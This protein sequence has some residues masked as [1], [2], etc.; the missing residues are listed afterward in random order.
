MKA[1]ACLLS[2]AV[3]VLFSII[4]GTISF[5]REKP[6]EEKGKGLA[7]VDDF[8]PGRYAILNI[9]NLWAWER[10]DGLSNHSPQG[11]CG[12]FFPRNTSHIIYQD[13]I[14][15]GSKAYLD[16]GKTQ[17]APLGQTIRVGGATYGTG[18]REGWV[19]GYGANAI[20]VNRDH[21]F[22]RLFRIRRGYSEMSE[23][24]LIQDAADCIE[25][26][27][28]EVTADMI[29]VVRDDYAWSW[30]NW[31]VHH[32]APFIDRNG[33][34]VYDPPPPFNI[35]AD[36]NDPAYFGPADLI[37]GGYDEPGIAGADL[38]SPADQVIFGIWNDLDREASLSRFGS[39]P[40]GLEI[41]STLW[42]YNRADALG[43]IFFRKIKF[44][45]KGGVEIDD[46]G[47]MG[48]FY[49][50]S[51]YVCQWSDPDL[52]SWGDD[53]VGCDTTLSMGFVY[54]ANT[55]DIRYRDFGLPPPAGG[56]D[57]LQGP[58]V[59]SPGDVAVFDLEYKQGYRNLGMSGFSYFSAGSPY[60]DPGGGYDTNT[61]QWYKML[62]GYAPLS[63]PDVHY[64][65]PPGVEPGP[66]PLSGDP[67]AGTGHI[68]GQGADYSFAPGDRRILC[69]SGPWTMAPGDTQEVVVALVVGLGSDR[70]SS[71]N[72][73]KFND[74]F[75][76]ATYNALFAIPSAPRTPVVNVAELDGRI[77]LEWGSVAGIADTE[78]R[79]NQPGAYQ[80][81]GYNVYQFPNQTASL[82]DAKRIVTYDLETDPA[83]ILDE[84]FD[85]VSGQILILPVQLG[86][87]SGIRRHFN[88]DRDYMLEE[89]EIINGKKYYLG[90]TAYS[91]TTVPGYLPA[92]LES[93]PMIIEATPVGPVNG[94]DYANVGSDASVT[95]V[96]GNGDVDITVTVIDPSR[97]TGDTY[98][99]TF[100]NDPGDGALTWNLENV[101]TGMPLLNRQRNFSGDSPN[102]IVEGLL[103]TLEGGIGVP[104]D[105]TDYTVTPVSNTGNYA[106]DSYYVSGW[107]ISAQAADVFGT[108]TSDVS[109]LKNDIEL[110]FTGEYGAK[111]G[112]V[113][114][115]KEGTGSIATIYRAPDMANHPLN[116]NPGSGDRFTVR[117]PFEV[118]DVDRNMQVNLLVYDRTQNPTDDPF[119]AFSPGDRMYV[120]LNALPYKEEVL[121]E[122]DDAMLT[123]NLVFRNTDWQKGDV[124]RIQYDDPLQAGIDVYEFSTT[125]FTQF[126]I[127]KGDINHDGSVDISDVVMNINFILQ[128]EDPTG[129]QEYA[130]DYNSDLRVNIA[131]VVGMINRILD[132][133]KILAKAT[134][135]Q[136]VEMGLPVQAVM[137]DNVLTLPLEMMSDKSIAGMQIELLYDPSQLKP[138]SPSFEGDASSRISTVQNTAEA[139]R[140]IYLFYSTE[141]EIITAS[142]LPSFQFE[143]ITENDN[144]H[145]GITLTKAVVASARG[146][147][148]DIQYGNKVAFTT[149]QPG[150]Y[151]LY[152]NYPNPFN[153]TTSIKYD[154]PV[155]SAVTI[156]I[157]NVLGQKVRTLLDEDVTAGSHAIRWDGRNDNAYELS[158]NIYFVRFRANHFVRHQKILLVK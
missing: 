101:T 23:V 12:V 86:S 14:V 79:V 107:A 136:P 99:V 30:N 11:N 127:L 113:I 135:T 44:I 18:S 24:A 123:W 130:A 124:V 17:P 105:F 51:M 128:N 89:E 76:Q 142:D 39:Y 6:E 81:E 13:G 2:I 87:N 96:A 43:N 7:K 126:D 45:N 21:E 157:Y 34:G 62:R 3:I 15:W 9:N 61:I 152:Q 84:K 129:E 88:F 109:I 108:G 40:T 140:V 150:Q 85:E 35:T 65:H 69:V 71:I 94:I 80:F 48:I 82:R 146:I 58:V 93:V 20:P 46:Q 70:L 49:L 102:P 156:E 29:Q 36:P 59:P 149:S 144:L 95:H 33:N 141:N 151:A 106:I 63:D 64:N 22:A 5:A 122:A 73:M 110:R 137:Q 92:S 41:Q 10:E 28:N 119:Y 68:D 139:G 19:V 77:L 42:G 133:S 75:A 134:Y 56:Y 147:S 25:M 153:A 148:M 117:I 158:A 90:V 116:P 104:L 8:T 114:P 55:V 52:G 1:R 27:T 66:F 111:V 78:G 83:V 16:A 145:S 132:L 72:V 100:S 97:I 26:S 47:N 155:A 143:I 120:F 98:R 57:F 31:P 37:D 67:V 54:N 74:R 4:R 118:W 154:L 138:L 91:R 121:T 60:S 38:N 131:D 50:D 115:V 125:A 32:G 112:T 103:V 53:L